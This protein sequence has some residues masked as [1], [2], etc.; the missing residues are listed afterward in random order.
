MISILYFIPI[1]TGTTNRYHNLTI[2]LLL[3]IAW[4]F[5]SASQSIHRVRDESHACWLPSLRCFC[6]PTLPRL[7]KLL[8]LTLDLPRYLILLCS[9]F[10][11]IHTLALSFGHSFELSILKK[12]RKDLYSTDEVFHLYRIL[13]SG[14]WFQKVLLLPFECTSVLFLLR[15]LR[16]IRLVDCHRS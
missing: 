6:Y 14:Y 9:V 12:I 4:P 13:L 3:I 11:K 5:Q 1:S 7:T 2:Q 15:I 10:T 16:C 8:Q